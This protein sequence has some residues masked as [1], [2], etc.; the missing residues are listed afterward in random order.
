MNPA[1]PRPVSAVALLALICLV[2]L[3]PVATEARS[4]QDRQQRVAVTVLGRN[5]VPVTDLTIKDFTVR[6]DRSNREI[7]SVTPATAADHIVLL[8]DDSQATMPMVNDLRRG[9]TSFANAITSLD[10]PPALRLTTFGDRPTVRV[11]FTPSFSAISRGID[12]IFPQAGAGGTLLEALIE[13]CKD[14]RSRKIERPLILVFVNE[15]GPE[16]SNA[17]RDQVAEAIREAGARLWTIVLEDRQGPGLSGAAHERSL[18][19]GDVTVQSGGFTK[20]IL[21]QQAI[22][23]AFES[24]ARA[25]A[26]SYEITYARPESLIPPSRLQI[27]VRDNSLKVL[28]P[29]WTRP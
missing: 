1:L 3:D 15:Q 22:G 18:V 25:M 19:L 16:F 2:S 21:N 23:A 10:T 26:S 7:I 8:V 28:A 5:D 12:R 6:E 11:D 14:L 4:A 27:E 29:R 17:S 13:T 20:A 9:L 24:A